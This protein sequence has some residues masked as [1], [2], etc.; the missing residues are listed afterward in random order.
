MSFAA[1]S[2][3][4][5][6]SLISIGCRG[7]GSGPGEAGESH[8]SVQALR[9]WRAGLPVRGPVID[10][11]DNAGHYIEH[12][13]LDKKAEAGEIKFVVIDGPGRAAVRG[14][15]DALVREVIDACCL[16]R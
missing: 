11:A 6:A 12:M 9:N 14:A 2:M 16:Q 4:Y 3:R 1:R 7:M 15:P 10:A 13:R 8:S 5:D